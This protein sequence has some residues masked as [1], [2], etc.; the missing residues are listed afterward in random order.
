MKT[1]FALTAAFIVGT[2]ASAFA[3]LLLVRHFVGLSEMD[4]FTAALFAWPISL[5]VL[6]AS[7]G[8]GLIAIMAVVAWK[9]NDV[10]SA[11]QPDVAEEP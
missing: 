2:L 4:L 5:P 6:M 9:P 3:A 11:Q 1:A 8:G 7:P 10:K